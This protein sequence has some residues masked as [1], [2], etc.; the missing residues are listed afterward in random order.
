MIDD[1]QYNPAED[2]FQA[3]SS[4]T[5]AKA[6]SKPRGAPFPRELIIA[7]TARRR[8]RRSSSIGEARS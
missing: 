7:L 2:G 8:L 5:G 6:K 1:E 4:T 3:N